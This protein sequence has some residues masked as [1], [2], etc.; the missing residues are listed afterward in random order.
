MK[1][2]SITKFDWIE[3]EPGQWEGNPSPHRFDAPVVDVWKSQNDSVWFCNVQV[4]SWDDTF[5]GAKRVAE[6]LYNNWIATHPVP[7]VA[8]ERAAVARAVAE[9]RAAVVAWLRAAPTTRMWQQAPMD[10]AADCIECVE[11]RREEER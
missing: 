5:N 10:D 11:H 1:K 6:N 4:H 3:V 2:G 9:E 7:R 8:K